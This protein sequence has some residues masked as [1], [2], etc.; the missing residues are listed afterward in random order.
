MPVNAK[1]S[2]QLDPA[3]LQHARLRAGLTSKQ[4]FGRADISDRTGYSAARGEG[5][6]MSTA[7][8]LAQALGIADVNELLADAGAVFLPQGSGPPPEWE[9][10]RSLTSWISS[11]NG[12]QYR[13]YRLEHKKLSGELARAKKFDLDNVACDAAGE[14]R[15]V[16]LTRH[17]QVCR[18]LVPS[19][20]FPVNQSVSES[21]DDRYLWVI[22]SWP[23]GKSLSE[24]QESEVIASPAVPAIMVS[25]A[26][27]LSQLHASDIV[28][29]D[30]HPDTIYYD[31]ET[32]QL[33][34]VDLELAKLLD[35]SP[36]VVHGELTHNPFRAPECVGHKIDHTA[37]IYSWAQMLSYLVTGRMPATSE[38][39]SDAINLP[40]KLL[41]LW[42][43]CLADSYRDRPQSFEKL[44]PTVKRWKP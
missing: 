38:T 25:L 20:Y 7:Q 36:T 4:L 29:R 10:T 37:D 13:V 39:L 31:L 1:G 2:L 35:G 33:T 44:I 11:A 3:K 32:G 12:L 40:P 30:L 43:T 14:M 23:S 5:I 16:L 27:A 34:I 19:G 9:P 18:K 22:D 41:A 15:D 24:L 8:S 6:S 42:Q 21:G 26:E 17:P 28:L